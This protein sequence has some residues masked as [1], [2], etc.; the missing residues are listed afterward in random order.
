MGRMARTWIAAVIAALAVAG[1][2]SCGEEDAE[3]LPGDTAREITAN[4]DS[5]QQLADE[6]D[7]IGAESAALQVSEQIDELG[8]VDLELKEALRDGATRLNE[9]VAECEEEEA[10]EPADTVPAEPETEEDEPKEKGKG[11]EKEGKEDKGK[12]QGPPEN[13]PPP[14][15][16]GDDDGGEEGGGGAGE[17]GGTPSGGVGP[18]SPVEEGGDN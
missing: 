9:V 16:E 10:V 3:L 18:G 8:G 11:K 4:L 1:L 13:V 17:G 15:S 2:Y 7:C 14:A 5:V 12:G 6:G